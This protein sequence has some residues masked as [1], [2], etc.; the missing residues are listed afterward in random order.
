MAPESAETACHISVL[1]RAL[2][3]FIFSG[4]SVVGV[5]LDGKLVGGEEEF[6]ED[7][8]VI[9]VDGRN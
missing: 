6:H 1:P 3:R 4:V 5:Y 9:V 7:G 2:A 8:K